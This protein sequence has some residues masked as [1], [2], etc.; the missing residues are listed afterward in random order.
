MHT[1]TRR[2]EMQAKLEKF[3]AEKYNNDSDKM[4][5]LIDALSE[6]AETEEEASLVEEFISWDGSTILW[7]N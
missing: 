1:H 4:D 2:N 7:D 6:G 5:V 3:I